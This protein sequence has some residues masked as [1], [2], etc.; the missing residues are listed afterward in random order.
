[1]RSAAILIAASL[2]SATPAAAKHAPRPPL[3]ALASAPAANRSPYVVTLVDDHDSALPI[4]R[5]D[6]HYFLAG[7]IGARYKI[8]VENP[9]EHRVEA[10]VAVDGIDV[11][12]DK[13]NASIGENGYVL[14]AHGS[15]D[16][17][18]FRTS[19]DFVSAFRFSAPA[20]SHADALGARA[21]IG[22]IRVA[23]FDEK[24]PAPVHSLCHPLP[25]LRP[26][27]VFA[28]IPIPM[29]AAA[30][31]APLPPAP[32]AQPV[33]AKVAALGTAAGERIFWSV[34]STSFIRASIAPV[35][36]A[37]LHYTDDAGLAAL[38]ISTAP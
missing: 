11:L 37:E 13:P 38:G 28:P 8:H 35:A 33:P 14:A 12:D 32:P 1:M 22:V 10:V 23:M 25:P 26:K 9:T 18:G 36:T 31:S 19:P 34:G 20:D 24:A 3:I 21:D 7:T 16:I 15:V 4:H 6:D 27:K 30:P 5:V 17:E 2:L 29:P